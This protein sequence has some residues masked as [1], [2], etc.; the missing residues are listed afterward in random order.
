MNT[1]IS[2]SVQTFPSMIHSSAGSML[3]NLSGALLLVVIAI[4]VTALVLRRSRWGGSL[5]KGK[6]MLTVRYRHALGQREQVVIVEVAQRCLLLGVTP[7]G[8]TLLTEI[9]KNQCDAEKVSM[10]STGNFQ[11]MLLRQMIKKPG[12]KL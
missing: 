8:I 12:S 9:D 3:L 5:L 1:P 4:I 2:Q 10:E 6:N 11:Q 7:G